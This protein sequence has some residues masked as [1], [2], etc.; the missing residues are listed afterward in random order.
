MGIGD[1]LSRWF[2][3]EGIE[4]APDQEIGA[5]IARPLLE[6]EPKTAQTTVGDAAPAAWQAMDGLQNVAAGLGTSRDKRYFSTYA[7]V[8]PLTLQQLDTM[9]RSSWLA[10]RIV[11]TVAGD[12]TRQGVSLSWDG[13]D[14]D[15]GGVAA[16]EDAQEDFDL[17]GKEHEALKWGRLYGGGA[18]FIGMAGEDPMKPLNLNTIKKG[19]LQFLHVL[20]RNTVFPSGELDPALGPHVGQPLFYMIGDAMNGAPR[21]H[22]SRIVIFRGRV[23]PRLAWQQNGYWDDSELQNVVESTQ[24]YDATRAGIASMVWEANVDILAI[25]GLA[26]KLAESGGETAITNRLLAALTMKSFNRTLVI[27]K[28]QE[29]WHQKTTQF[30]GVKDVI[31]RFMIDVCGAADIPMTRLFGQS[32]AGLTSTGEHD[33]RNYYDHVAA[34]EKSHLRPQRKRL[35]GVLVRSTLGRM[36]E[37][38]KV[39]A[40]PLWQ[41]SDKERGEI[42]KLRADRDKTYVDMGAVTEGLVARQLKDDGTYSR[43][44][45]EDVELAEE[46]AAQP[47]PVVPAA[48]PVKPVPGTASASADPTAADGP[49]ADET[50]DKA[51]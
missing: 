22:W 18:I 29:E 15:E 6:P 8:T 41:V 21:V 36:P 40:N 49:S 23:L 51:A 7:K 19:S 27:D 4:R 35:Y 28:D 32:A 50:G 13:Y 26:K 37:N 3:G 47:D 42:Q 48:A 44:E 17:P 12:M 16:I 45:D 24:D 11:D 20:D 5:A 46:L 10:G 9:Y 33:L 43:M 34:K 25:A 1:S 31:D 14:K 2:R 38:F 39:K 30:G